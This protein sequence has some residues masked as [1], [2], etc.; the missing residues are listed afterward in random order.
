MTVYQRPYNPTSRTSIVIKSHPIPHQQMR[1]KHHL[2]RA[3]ILPPLHP[4]HQRHRPRQPPRNN[5]RIIHIPR[6]HRHPKRRQKHAHKP[7]HIHTSNRID[8]LPP[9]PRHPR[10]SPGTR[11]GDGRGGAG[12]WRRC[13]R[14]WR[15]RR[16]SRRR[17]RRRWVRGRRLGL[18]GW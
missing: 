6:I 16:R 13:R 18:G 1:I 8:H 3:F 9:R 4:P 10:T 11:F 12:G 15:G 2:L 5:N 14:G 7:Q 17:R